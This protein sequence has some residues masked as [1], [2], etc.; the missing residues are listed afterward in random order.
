ML[1]FLE[2][3]DVAFGAEAGSPPEY[4]DLYGDGFDAVDVANA[5]ASFFF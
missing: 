1:G 4:G 2:A 5:A 3:S